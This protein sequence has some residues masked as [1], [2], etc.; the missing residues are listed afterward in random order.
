MNQS[1][2]ISL[3]L[4]TIPTNE[5]IF[6]SKFY[7]E[8][9]SNNAS[10]ELYYK[11]L[12]RLCKAGELC[13]ISKGTY[14]RPKTG[15]YGVVPPSEQQ[16]ISTFTKD[17]TGTVIGYSLYNQLQLT[18]QVPKRIEVLSS[19]LEQQS[20][21]IRN[22]RI[23]HCSIDYSTETERIIHML[24]VLKGFHTIEDINYLAF[25][26]YC[27]A[28]SKNYSDEST[29]YV[30]KHMQYQ[31]RTISFLQNILSYY[32]VSNTLNKYLSKLSDYKHPSMEAIYEAA[33]LA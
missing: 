28:F 26:R 33:H 29:T 8:H 9:I 32:Q 15:R 30:L 20:K 16:I 22:I 11:T 13:K 7:R 1:R 27:E 3:A 4:E 10:E 31:K 23:T 6:A 2:A 17:Q 14:Y 5:L 25:I 18:T 21:T 12:E 24:E 19:Q